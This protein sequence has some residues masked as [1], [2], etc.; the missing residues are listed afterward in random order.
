M[1]TS[2][3]LSCGVRAVLLCFLLVSGRSGG[4]HAQV[5]SE[6]ISLAPEVTAL[7]PECSLDLAATRCRSNTTSYLEAP[8][9]ADRRVPTSLLVAGGISGGAIGLVVGARV[10][11]PLELGSEYFNLGTIF[12]AGFG[13]ALLLPLGVHIV[14]GRKG[15]YGQGALISSGIMLGAVALAIPTHGVSLLA[16]PPLQLVFSIRNERRN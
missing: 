14:N 10:L 1:T 3:T 5:R 7:G 9:S 15:N 2:I 12:G 8:D 16:A 11:T 13:E 6:T 4:I